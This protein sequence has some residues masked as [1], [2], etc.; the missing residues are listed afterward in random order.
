MMN[1]RRNTGIKSR[2]IRGTKIAAI[3]ENG[4]QLFAKSVIITLLMIILVTVL[5]RLLIYLEQPSVSI[6]EMLMWFVAGVLYLVVSGSILIIRSNYV[7]AILIPI[8]ISSIKVLEVLL[9]A[10]KAL[11]TSYGHQT[12]QGFEFIPSSTIAFR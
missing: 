1:Q 12:L 9:T 4:I 11:A 7:R 3:K 10:G 8:I 5:N 6:K 2:I